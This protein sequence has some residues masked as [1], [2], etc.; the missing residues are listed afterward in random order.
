MTAR[1]QGEFVQKEKV[2]ALP[3]AAVG[4]FG[5][6]LILSLAYGFQY[7]FPGAKLLQYY[8]LASLPFFLILIGLSWYGVRG[9][10][11]LPSLSRPPLLGFLLMSISFILTAFF[12][13]DVL[14]PM[15]WPLVAGCVVG[16]SG[17]CQFKWGT[18]GSTIAFL[19]GA[20]VVYIF[21][22]IRIP[23]VS[24]AANMLETIDLASR[25]FL[26]GETP[27]RPF[28]TSGGDVTLPY[29]PGLWLP[30]VPL[31]K[32][33]LDMRI[34]NLA[35]LLLIVFLFERSLP[36][37][38]RADI[39]SLTLYPFVLSS[40]LAL[41]VV[42]G[43]VWPYWLFLLATVL[44]LMKARLLPAAI[45][46]GL[47]LASRQPALFLVGP[48][49]AYAYRELG[50]KATLMY[51]AVAVI[52]YLCLVL[53]FAVWTGKLFWIY[54]YLS[55]SGGGGPDQPHVSAITFL[56]LWNWGKSTQ[57]Y[58]QV[59]IVI[60][61]M[62]AILMRTKLDPVWFV[63]IAGVTYCWLVFF[64]S[65]AV[66]YVYFPGFFLIAIALSAHLATSLVRGD[67]RSGSQKSG[68]AY[69]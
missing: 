29:L 51:M 45:F 11:A 69:S 1:T 27:Y 6:I 5:L 36:K 7:L 3:W 68:Q 46:F 13:S 67:A 58:W 17:Y 64:N 40:P 8:R 38:T 48:L 30:Y 14:R 65:Y 23:M 32:L 9:W 54:S 52:V 39:L 59:L 50:L 19:C 41:M 12:Q 63:F 37:A 60:G 20:V 4:L 66:R 62:S 49:A 44:F 55:L 15:P 10:S 28:E 16:V 22:I 61:S 57:K 34:F 2:A 56:Q 43:H 24:G 53:P 25:A 31:I 21:F 33:G 35:A 42:N 18:R 47:S 26:S